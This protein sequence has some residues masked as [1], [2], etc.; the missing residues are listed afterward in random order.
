ML[1]AV[2]A[3]EVGQQSSDGGLPARKHLTLEPSFFAKSK[4]RVQGF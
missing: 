1:A 4:W 3:F 2:S